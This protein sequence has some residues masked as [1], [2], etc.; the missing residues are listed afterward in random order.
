MATQK[1]HHLFGQYNFL[2]LSASF[3]VISYFSP[4]ILFSL[5]ISSFFFVSLHSFN[6]KKS[7][8]QAV[9]QQSAH[10]YTIKCNKI[11]EVWNKVRK[12]CRIERR[13]V[14]MM[15]K[16]K[17][18]RTRHLRW[19]FTITLTSIVH[20]I[21]SVII[22]QSLIWCG[23]NPVGFSCTLLFLFWHFFFN[24]LSRKMDC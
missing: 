23:Y 7:Y 11:T 22:I 9:G 18:E 3:L 8:R 20:V 6:H 16:G 24:R 17:R 1:Q 14:Q 5:R 12:R 10:F 4:L 21:T 2:L 15:W 13:P 19:I